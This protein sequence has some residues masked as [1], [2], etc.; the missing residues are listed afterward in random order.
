MDSWSSTYLAM[1][2]PEFKCTLSTLLRRGD[3]D[4]QQEDKPSAVMV[5]ILIVGTQERNATA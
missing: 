1:N 3:E 4:G 5:E 2:M